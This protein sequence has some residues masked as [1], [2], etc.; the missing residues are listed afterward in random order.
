MRG[1]LYSAGTAISRP[2][3]IVVR[4]GLA[5]RA[6]S[7]RKRWLARISSSSSFGVGLGFG[8]GV[9]V[10]D[11]GDTKASAPMPALASEE[12]PDARAKTAINSLTETFSM[13]R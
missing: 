12:N 11:F 8:V 7:P 3:N 9:G 2:T 13:F 1:A 10:A 6:G 5:L 4:T